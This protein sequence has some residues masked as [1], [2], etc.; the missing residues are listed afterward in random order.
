MDPNKAS[1][2]W[3]SE[4][5]VGNTPQN[6]LMVAGSLCISPGLQTAH[7]MLMF[8]LLDQDEMR[9]HCRNFICT[10]LQNMRISSFRVERRKYTI[11]KQV[12]PMPVISFYKL[13][14]KKN[15]YRGPHIRYL[16]LP[17][18]SSFG[19]VVP[20]KRIVTLKSTRND[21][22]SHLLP[23]QNGIWSSCSK[24]HMYRYQPVTYIS[25]LEFSLYS[26]LKYQQIRNNNRPSLCCFASEQY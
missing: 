4:I 11:Q 2:Y 14:R 24:P 26:L 15:H 10:K 6:K 20:E 18:Y 7:I 9:N 19:F 17:R 5:V 21:D 12:P 3:Q 23:D 16:S 8:N 25:I 22:H 13:K 1:V